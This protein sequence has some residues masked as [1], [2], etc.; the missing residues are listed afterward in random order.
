MKK[1]LSLLGAMGMLA[2]TGAVASTVVSCKAS[3][4]DLSTIKGDDLKL[5]PTANTEA[6]AKTAVIAQIKAKLSKTVVEKTDITFS[7]YK[8]ATSAAA[9]SIKVTAVSSSKN[10]KGSATFSLAFSEAPAKAE[11]STVIKV[12]ELGDIT[13]AASDGKPTADEILVG[14]KAK[15]TEAK[16]LTVSDFAASEITTSGA[17]LTGAGDKYQGTV[18]VTFSKKAASKAELSTVIKV[19]ELGN[20]TIAASDGKPNADEILVGVKAK[21]TEAKDLTVSDFAA[22]EITTSGATLTGAGDKY[23]GTVKVTFS[24]G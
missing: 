14:V 17:T 24:K 10:V 5:K 19:V 4:A 9:G 13:I 22:S 21:N 20:I 2:S 23:Q 16:D 1:L 8:D 18:K 12:V 3:T 6:A 7:D 15:N 11:L